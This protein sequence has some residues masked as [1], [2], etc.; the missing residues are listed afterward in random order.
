M[1]LEQQDR[2][3]IDETYCPPWERVVASRAVLQTQEVRMFIGWFFLRTMMFVGSRT[4]ADCCPGTDSTEF[5]PLT[6]SRINH[7]LRSLPVPTAGDNTFRF[8]RYNPNWLKN[9]HKRSRER[10][11]VVVSRKKWL[12]PERGAPSREHNFE[13]HPT[14][15]AF[16]LAQITE[17]L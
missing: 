8:K 15:R 11:V 2:K 16:V 6:I 14:I 4:L 17:K 5:R 1:L 12:E 10:F 7:S 9:R 3:L 13:N